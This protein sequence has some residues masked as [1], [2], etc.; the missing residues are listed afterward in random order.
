MRSLDKQGSPGLASC[1]PAKTSIPMIE[2]ICII[3]HY[4]RL[5]VFVSRTIS[6]FVLR[7]V[8]E[9]LVIAV[10]R[11]LPLIVLLGMIGTMFAIV[12][13]TGDHAV[14]VTVFVAALARTERAAIF[15]LGANGHGCCEKTQAHA[16]KNQRK[17]QTSLFHFSDLLYTWTQIKMRGCTAPS[18]EWQSD[19]L[20]AGR[21]LPATL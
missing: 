3:A 17:Q 15:G 20:A 8:A 6:L 21:F 7:L 14:A 16:R 11:I 5:A 19:C 4:S 18:A 12:V 9:R 2:R 1:Q 13:Q 10:V